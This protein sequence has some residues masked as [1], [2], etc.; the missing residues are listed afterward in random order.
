MAMRK[1]KTV[2]KT[3]NSLDFLL[4]YGWVILLIILIV[5]ALLA[6]MQK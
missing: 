2:R 5:G 1:H 6:L 3:Q 4:A